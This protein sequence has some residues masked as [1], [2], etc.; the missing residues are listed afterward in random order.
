MASFFLVLS[1]TVGRGVLLRGVEGLD[2]KELLLLLKGVE[3]LARPEANFP[4]G[5]DKGLVSVFCFLVAWLGF[6]DG[7]FLLFPPLTGDSFSDSLSGSSSLA[8]SLA[9]LSSSLSISFLEGLNSLSSPLSS[10]SLSIMMI[11]L[12]FVGGV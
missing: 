7:R 6:L 12:L 11:R 3:G 1:H 5:V 8:P 2:S 4:M 9:S 10:S